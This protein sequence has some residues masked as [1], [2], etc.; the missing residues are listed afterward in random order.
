MGRREVIT[1]GGQLPEI[2]RKLHEQYLNDWYI[3]G[4][5]TERKS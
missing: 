1:D 5:G 4:N 2:L 3:E